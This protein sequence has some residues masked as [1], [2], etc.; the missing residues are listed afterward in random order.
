MPSPVIPALGTLKQGRIQDQYET[1]KILSQKQEEGLGE[2]RTMR[3]EEEEGEIDNNK[4]TVLQDKAEKNVVPSP[5]EVAHPTHLLLTLR[6]LRK[7]FSI[8]ICHTSYLY[9][10]GNQTA[11]LIG[12]IQGLRVFMK[13]NPQCQPYNQ[14]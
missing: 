1:Y 2:R 14:P 6:T 5:A 4:V 12:L 13:R 9:Y 11:Y 3:T 8:F 10:K 7:L